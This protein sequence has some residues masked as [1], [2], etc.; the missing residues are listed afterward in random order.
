MSDD[1]LI[2]TRRH[3]TFDELETWS[4]CR[5]RI[6]VWQ[7]ESVTPVCLVSQTSRRDHPSQ[8]ITA[9]ANYVHSAILKFPELGVSVFMDSDD[10]KPQAI[11][12]R[13]LEYVSFEFFGCR[14]RL[15]LF[16]PALMARDWKFLEELVG[17]RIER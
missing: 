14:F 8:D 2:A 11:P 16:K 5:Y 4:G 12:H 17:C 6:R 3:L 9:I 15:H 1:A 13:V 7:G 10:G